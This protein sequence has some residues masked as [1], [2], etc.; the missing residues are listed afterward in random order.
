MLRK[1]TP[2]RIS[3]RMKADAEKADARVEVD[4][5]KINIR[6]EADAEKADA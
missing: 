2:K 6:F 5:R 4:G 3:T 1:L